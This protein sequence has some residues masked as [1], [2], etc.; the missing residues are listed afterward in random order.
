MKILFLCTGNRCRSQMAENFA[1]IR[2]VR[3]EIDM[4]VRTFYDTIIRR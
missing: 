1:G 3:D 4:A 2:R